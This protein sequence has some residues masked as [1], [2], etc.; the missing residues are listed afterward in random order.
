MWHP[1]TAVRCGI[2]GKISSVHPDAGIEAH[3][4]GHW[5]VVKNL[6]RFY[7]VDAVVSVGIYRFTCSDVFDDSVGGRFV[8]FTFLGDFVAT[9]WGSVV[10]VS[11]GDFRNAN[12][13]PTFVKISFLLCSI[14]FHQRGAGD[15]IAVPIRNIIMNS[16]RGMIGTAR[17]LLPQRVF[18]TCEVIGPLMTTV[19]RGQQRGND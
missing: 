4:V 6:A 13:F 5:G 19:A 7:F 15:S 8:I 11:G 12:E 3:E 16:R 17:S 1:N 10:F 18:D 9:G 2:T 14:D